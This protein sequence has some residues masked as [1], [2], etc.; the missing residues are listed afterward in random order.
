MCRSVWRCDQ[1][2]K[3]FAVTQD[4]N[5]MLP[6]RGAGDGAGVVGYYWPDIISSLAVKAYLYSK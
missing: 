3:M 1:C 4:H 6:R 2:F 5:N